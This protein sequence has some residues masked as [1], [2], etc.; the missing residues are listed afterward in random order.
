MRVIFLP[1]FVA[2]PICYFR[3]L[4]KLSKRVTSDVVNYNDYW[5]YESVATLGA[6]I[7]SKRVSAEVDAVVG[8]SFG[9]FVAI[10]TASVLARSGAEVKLHLIDP[11]NRTMLGSTVPIEIE[12]R[13]RANPAY[14]YLFSLMEC[15][16]THRDCV[17]SNIVFLADVAAALQIELPCTVYVAGD[18]ATSRAQLEQFHFSHQDATIVHCPGFNHNNIVDCEA[19]VD[20]ICRR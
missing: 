14:K 13:L 10:E 16:L 3:M 1:D 9:A 8:Y 6:E 5:P 20:G 17:L 12:A 4:R 2:Y 7:A 11:P 19:I 15:D 18:H